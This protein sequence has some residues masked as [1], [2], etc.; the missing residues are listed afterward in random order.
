MNIFYI[1]IINLVY[2]MHIIEAKSNILVMLEKV[3]MFKMYIRKSLPSIN[4]RLN[5]LT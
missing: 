5:Y 4:G 3:Y 1:L 2:K